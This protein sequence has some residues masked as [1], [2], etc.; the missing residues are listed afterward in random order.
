ME[1]KLE[2]R[3]YHLVSWS[4]FPSLIKIWNPNWKVAVTTLSSGS[5]NPLFLQ[6]RTRAGKYM[7]PPFLSGHPNPHLKQDGTQGVKF[8]LPPR[9][10]GHPPRMAGAAPSVPLH[11][12]Q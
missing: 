7:L 10:P 11:F 2:S 3:C 8:M 5:F 4:S 12:S 6:D 9:L 1:P